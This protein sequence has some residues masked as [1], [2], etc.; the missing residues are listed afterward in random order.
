MHGSSFFV[1]TE[2]APASIASQ[3][4]SFS[5]IAERMH[6]LYFQRRLFS[7]IRMA[8]RIVSITVATDLYDT[9]R[10]G[11]TAITIINR[12]GRKSAGPSIP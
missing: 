1:H 3:K 8:A 11:F 7:G 2:Q 5:P 10:R 6:R 4:Y 9:L 12:A